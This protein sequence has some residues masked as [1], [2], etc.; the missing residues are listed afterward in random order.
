MTVATETGTGGGAAAVALAEGL[1]VEKRPVAQRSPPQIKAAA[2]RMMGSF[3]VVFILGF[4]V[5]RE[6]LKF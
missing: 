3:N 5:M 1:F 2:I 4:S 6:G